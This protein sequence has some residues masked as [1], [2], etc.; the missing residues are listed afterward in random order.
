MCVCVSGF[1]SPSQLEEGKPRRR[2]DEATNLREEMLPRNY[3]VLSD[4]MKRQG[5]DPS[6]SKSF[7]KHSVTQKVQ[8]KHHY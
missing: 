1:R 5:E 2:K 7:I 8:L 6:R 3:I 4:D